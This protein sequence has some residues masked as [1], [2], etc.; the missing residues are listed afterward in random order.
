MHMWEVKNSILVPIWAHSL[1]MHPFKGMFCLTL[2]I[3]ADALYA[4]T[5]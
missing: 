5:K 3:N 2:L 4:H 1:G